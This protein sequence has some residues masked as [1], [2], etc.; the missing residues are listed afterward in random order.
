MDTALEVLLNLAQE[1]T[2]LVSVYNVFIKGILDYIDNLSLSQIRILFDIFSVLALK[3]IGKIII[4]T[5]FFVFYFE[6]Q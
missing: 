1:N 4:K 5:L 3:V 6:I 2:A